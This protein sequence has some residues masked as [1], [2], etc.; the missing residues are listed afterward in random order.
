MEAVLTGIGWEP[1]AFIPWRIAPAQYLRIRIASVIW[2]LP[3]GDVLDIGA[4]T[5][6][7]CF[8]VRVHPG[9][10]AIAAVAEHIV[11]VSLLQTESPTFQFFGREVSRL[12][13]HG[14]VK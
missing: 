13:G 2:K 1:E 9:G 5:G 4:P 11:E 10:V 6:A 8:V 7:G 3:A 12:F 14:A